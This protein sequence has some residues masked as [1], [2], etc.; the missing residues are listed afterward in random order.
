VQVFERG[1]R[2]RQRVNNYFR[3]L[4]NSPV[5]WTLCQTSRKANL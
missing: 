3:L 4:F 2:G 1:K 5:S